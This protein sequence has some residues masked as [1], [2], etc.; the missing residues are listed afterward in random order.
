MN[1]NEAIEKNLNEYGICLDEV[2]TC[3]VRSCGRYDLFFYKVRIIDYTNKQFKLGIMD[4]FL[5]MGLKYEYQMYL[6]QTFS[7][8][9]TL[10]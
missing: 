5:L 1:N 8:S 9:C 10:L 4:L 7:L 6:E 2:N 3:Y